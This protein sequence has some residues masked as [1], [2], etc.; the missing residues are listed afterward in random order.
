M[1][2]YQVI[3]FIPCVTACYGPIL[4]CIQPDFLYPVVDQKLRT[5]VQGV[6]SFELNTLTSL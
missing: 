1:V 3:I 5:H 4:K 2:I 6:Q